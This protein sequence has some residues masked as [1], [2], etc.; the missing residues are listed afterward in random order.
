MIK[1]IGFSVKGEIYHWVTSM[2]SQLYCTELI[3]CVGQTICLQIFVD[4]FSVSYCMHTHTHTLK[5][6]FEATYCDNSGL[7]KDHVM[8]TV[9]SS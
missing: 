7:V 3:I 1:S 5:G 2:Y 9:V 8:A 4:L 6:Y